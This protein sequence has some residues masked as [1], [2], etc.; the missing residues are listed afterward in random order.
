M[1]DEQIKTNDFKIAGY[2]KISHFYK[3]SAKPQPAP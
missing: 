1:T 2:S 3:P